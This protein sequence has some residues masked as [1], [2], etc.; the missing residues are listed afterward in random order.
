[1][2]KG[3]RGRIGP[4]PGPGDAELDVAGAAGACPLQPAPP[5]KPDSSGHENKSQSRR[6]DALER[7]SCE[8]QTSF[9]FWPALF[10]CR[11][12]IIDGESAYIRV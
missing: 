1:M 9:V 10:E 4:L 11:T 5:A 3:D 12:V 8:H 2:G 7:A 6:S